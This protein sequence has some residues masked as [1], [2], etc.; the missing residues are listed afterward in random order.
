MMIKRPVGTMVTY[1]FVPGGL[2]GDLAIAAKLGATV[3]EILPD[4]RSLPDPGLLRSLVT[5][6]GLKIHSAH[7]CWGGQAILAPRVDLGSLSPK[8]HRESIDDIR[9]CIEWLHDAGGGHLVIHPG[10]L[11]DPEEKEARRDAL[12]QGLNTLADD[13]FRASVILCVENMP[14]GVYPG[15]LMNDLAT[16]VAEINRPEALGVALDTGHA[17]ISSTTTEETLAA[18]SW[19]RTTHVHD[20]D[21]KQ[22]SHLP[23]GLGTIGWESWAA[24]LEAI[25]YSGPVMLEC[26][27]HLRRYPESVSRMLV[28]LVQSLT[29]WVEL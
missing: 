27:R 29:G 5:D 12:L 15:S 18:G 17:H 7:G 9:R 28:E 20:N 16:L 26:I 10:G 6:S 13:A 11:S 24:S 4:W 25:H 1:G 21:G 19:L 2:E 14:S 3:V 23:P 22:D 8:T